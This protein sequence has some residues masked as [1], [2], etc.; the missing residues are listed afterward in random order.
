MDRDRK[1]PW[2]PTADREWLL[3]LYYPA[4][5]HTGT[6]APY[7]AVPEAK[8]LLTDRGRL[9]EYVTPERLAATRTHARD[10]ALPRPAAQRYPLPG[11]TPGP[12]WTAGSAG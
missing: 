7:M 9:G 3:S 5:A 1:D 6:P 11:R 4:L 8:A 2:V 12:A 10:G